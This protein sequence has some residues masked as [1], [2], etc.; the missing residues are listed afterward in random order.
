M[1][2]V[3]N[4]ENTTRGASPAPEPQFPELDKAL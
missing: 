1:R 2:T 4:M 3:K